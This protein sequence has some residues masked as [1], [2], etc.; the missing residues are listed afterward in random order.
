[1]RRI[2]L[3]ALAIAAAVAV[4]ASPAVAQ[5]SFATTARVAA[6][7]VPDTVRA[8]Q[9]AQ[10]GDERWRAYDLSGA[11]RDLQEAVEIM[12]ARDVY[13]GPT[14]EALAH[15]T[16][17]L[18]EPGR[19]AK[20]LVAASEEAARYGDLA[21]QVSALFEA[22]VLYS[23]QGDVAQA[24]ELLGRVERL[25]SSRYVPEELKQQIRRRMAE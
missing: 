20:V 19:A 2:P 7:A 8:Q 13:A 16:F 3:T 12:R 25:L 24:E 14:L 23:Q 18:A 21:L 9:L 4:A 17:A 5:R 10:R 22:S 15:V 11:R 1:M 6:R